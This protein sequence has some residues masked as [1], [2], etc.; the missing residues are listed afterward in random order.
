MAMIR[1][2]RRQPDKP[3]AETDLTQTQDASGNLDDQYAGDAAAAHMRISS[4]AAAE[5]LLHRPARRGLRCV[6]AH[7]HSCTEFMV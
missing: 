7:A 3:N 4:I 6:S 1:E 5:D 2:S